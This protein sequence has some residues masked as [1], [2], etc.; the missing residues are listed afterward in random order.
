MLGFGIE[1]AGAAAGIGEARAT[2]ACVGR[3][4]GEVSHGVSARSRRHR[5]LDVARKPKGVADRIA[6]V[7]VIA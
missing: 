5:R 7:I 1:S 3:R 2:E 4:S 6:K